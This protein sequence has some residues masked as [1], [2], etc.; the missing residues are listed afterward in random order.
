MPDVSKGAAEADSGRRFATTHWSVVLAAGQ[1][2][3]ADAADALAKLCTAYWYPL[4][5]YVRRQGL[6]AETAQDLTQEFFA[7]LLEKNYLAQADRARGSFRAFLLTAMKHF[8]ANEWDRVRA[9]KRGGGQR[10]ISLD[11]AAAENRYRAEPLDELSPDRIFE[12]RWALTLLEQTLCRLRQR[13][14]NAGKLDVFE[15]LKVFLTG[16]ETQLPYTKIGAE[17]RTSEGAVKV[18]VYRMRRRY[19]DLLRAEIAQTVSSPAEIEEE[20]R[21]LFTALGR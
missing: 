19:R 1:R 9:K 4:Y 21:D 17:W 16:S 13:Y 18:A 15:R 12:R 8:L 11:L 20:I 2:G 5:A 7:R 6:D 3:S 10:P 14:E